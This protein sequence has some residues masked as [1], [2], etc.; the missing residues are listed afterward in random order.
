MECGTNCISEFRIKN[1]EDELRR[2]E[3]G[4]SAAHREF[5]NRLNDLEKHSIQFASDIAHIKTA[6]DEMNENLKT[7]ME[8]PH[9]RYET[10]VACVITTIVGAVAGVLMSGI[11][12]M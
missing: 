7:I 11:L 3:E 12:P 1:L 8:T 10:I 6:V 4:N 9:K 2:V 5:Y